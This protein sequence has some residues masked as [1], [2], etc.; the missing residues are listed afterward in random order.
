VLELVDKTEEELAHWVP[1][2]I[3]SYAEERIKAGESREAAWTVSAEQFGTLLPDSKPIDGQFVMNLMVDGECVGVLWMGRPLNDEADT[4]FVF[5]VEID[6]P[7]RGHG[8]G[9]AAM[10]AAEAWALDR[11][12]RRIAL[13]VF[14]PNVTARSLY[15]SLGYGVRAT[16]MAKELEP[17]GRPDA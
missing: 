2:M 9:R 13:N 17:S 11:D 14:G 5:Y 7:H 12:G 10:L 3:A 6:E 8:L 1:A 16:A 15:D 4:W